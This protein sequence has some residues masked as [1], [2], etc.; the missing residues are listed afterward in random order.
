MTT[1]KGASNSILHGPLHK[2][3]EEFTMNK[4]LKFKI[5]ILV[6][7]LLTLTVQCIIIATKI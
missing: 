1:P 7:N 6:V 2:I 3:K 5:A 4:D